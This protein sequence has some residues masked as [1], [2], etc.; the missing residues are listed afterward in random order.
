MSMDLT[1]ERFIQLWQ[2][3]RSLREFSATTGISRKSASMRAAK[4]RKQGVPLK[5]FR[6]AGQVDWQRM[7]EIARE[8]LK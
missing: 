5:Y 8:S 3:A 1:A 2:E 6:N 7:A 4:Y